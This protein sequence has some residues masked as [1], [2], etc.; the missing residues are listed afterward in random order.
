MDRRCWSAKGSESDEGGVGDVL[1][2]GEGAWSGGEPCMAGESRQEG[3]G[4]EGGAGGRRCA[5]RR[6]K[7]GQKYSDWASQGEGA[8]RHD[9]LGLDRKRDARFP[10]VNGVL[11]ALSP[12]PIWMTSIP[13]NRL[14]FQPRAVPRAV[15]R[16]LLR[17]PHASSGRRRSIDR[18]HRVRVRE[19]AGTAN[20]VSLPIAA[21]DRRTGHLAR[22]HSR[23]GKDACLI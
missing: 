2:S 7:T 22:R 13:G 4:R 15:H 1:R 20:R 21:A 3:E 5:R 14:Y 19:H 12:R 6:R 23:T 11:P 9:E 10:R 8:R 16:P 17:D 18:T